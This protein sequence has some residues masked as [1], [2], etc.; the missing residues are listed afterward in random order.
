[1]CLNY[2]SKYSICKTVHSPSIRVFQ[3]LA[4][5]SF[6]KDHFHSH[7]EK[8]N[9]FIMNSNKNIVKISIELVIGKSY[10]FVNILGN[11]NIAF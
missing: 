7:T 9:I 6:F 10:L 11:K 8:K 5:F 2:T 1:M 4:M 3:F